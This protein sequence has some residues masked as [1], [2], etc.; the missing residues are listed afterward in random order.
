MCSF[1][2]VRNDRP[3]RSNDNDW[4]TIPLLYV[5]MS[6]SSC[7]S[8]VFFRVE[9]QC[10]RCRACHRVGK[11]TVICVSGLLIE[12]QLCRG[13]LLLAHLLLCVFV[14]L[15]GVR[16]RYNL[17]IDGSFSGLSMCFLLTQGLLGVADRLTAPAAGGHPVI[18]VV[19][20]CCLSCGVKYIHGLVGCGLP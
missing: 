20:I 14:L 12:R 13:F 9:A 19:K 2:Q 8:M 15:Y 6:V 3:W 5:S 10:T 17:R 4:C 1:W 11:S 7:S 16:L 18:Q